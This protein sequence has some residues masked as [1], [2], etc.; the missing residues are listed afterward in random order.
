M[1]PKFLVYIFL[2]SGAIVFG[3]IHFKN[4]NKSLKIL[5]LLLVT[6]W[7]SEMTGRI[8]SH[9]YKTSLPVYHFL[10][11]FQ[12]M[13]YLLLYIQILN[14]QK[15]QLLAFKILLLSSVLFSIVNTLYSQSLFLF[16]S[17]ALFLLSILVVFC[18]LLHF[19]SMLR[20]PG[21]ISPL[22]D[23]YFWISSG[24]LVFYCITFFLFGFFNPMLK[25][26]GHLPSWAGYIIFIA[27]L[28]LYGSYFMSLWFGRKTI[29]N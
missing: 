12:L 7:S 25:I 17:N 14:L 23:P 29:T 9:Y 22:K 4:L 19:L 15:R 2:L 13:L 26:A 1:T 16:P 27:N 8:I 18:S 6:V 11:P 20:K 5:L 3:L 21:T 28:L 10:L 24:N